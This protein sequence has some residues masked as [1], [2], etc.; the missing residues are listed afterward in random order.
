MHTETY[1]YSQGK[2]FLAKRLPSGEVGPQRWVGDVSE[3]TISLSVEDLTHKESYS[4]AKQEVKKIVTGKSGEVSAKFHE[5][6]AENLSLLL[7]GQATKIE[8]G[9]VTEEK[10]PAE[11][12]VGDRIALAHPK[13]SNVT[14]EDL[15]VGTD[16]IVDEIFGAIE[17]LKAQTGNTKAVAYSYG[18]VQNVALLTENSKDLFLRFEGLN[19][20]EDNEWTLVELYKVSFNPAESLSL[21]NNENSLDALNA[22]AKVL[23]D[24]T[25]PNDKLLGRFGRVIKIN[26]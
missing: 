18:D 16:F 13:V 2:V 5:F 1:S 25:K 11:I 10:L 6:S 23:A 26:K 21:I 8:A 15:T 19:L 7:L 24:T 3:L 22:K 20:A 14:I 12:A 9:S 4:G 17:F